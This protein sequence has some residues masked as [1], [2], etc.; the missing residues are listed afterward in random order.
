MI[1]CG[2]VIGLQRL[3]CLRERRQARLA[4]GKV[5]A[6]LCKLFL[7][8]AQYVAGGRCEGGN[9]PFEP[10]V[11]VFCWAIV[12]AWL[13]RRVSPMRMSCSSAAIVF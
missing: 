2:A 8:I 12:R 9:F 10:R 13:S 4:L 7:D 3:H 1:T 6:L 11:P 5:G